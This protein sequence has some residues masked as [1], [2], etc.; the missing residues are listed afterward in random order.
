MRFISAKVFLK[1][2]EDYFKEVNE[3]GKRNDE[4]GFS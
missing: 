3:Y 2:R 4:K 1:F